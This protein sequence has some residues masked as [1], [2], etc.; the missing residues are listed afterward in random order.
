MSKGQ[1]KINLKMLKLDP[2]NQD[3]I[4]INR[5]ISQNQ[6]SLNFQEVLYK[7]E[8]K[9]DQIEQI[10][11]NSGIFKLYLRK[12]RQAYITKAVDQ[13]SNPQEKPEVIPIPY[14]GIDQ[15]FQH[16]NGFIFTTK[17]MDGYSKL[18]NCVITEK[19]DAINQIGELE[20]N[21]EN[22]GEHSEVKDIK[23]KSIMGPI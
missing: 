3:N 13:N 7:F 16:Y 14:T 20:N 4:V 9:D 19:D 10:Y 1:L 18:Y 21:Q 11:T 22:N 12:D 2:L 6:E 5:K 15:V 8:K 17:S 23:I